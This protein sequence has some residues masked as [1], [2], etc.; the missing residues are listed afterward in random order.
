MRRGFLYVDC[1]R[2]KESDDQIIPCPQSEL[3]WHRHVGLWASD[4]WL[5]DDLFNHD[6]L[7]ASASG[8]WGCAG[9]GSYS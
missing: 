9:V 7:A 5:D 8:V 4:L 1:R 2:T 3:P 6:Q